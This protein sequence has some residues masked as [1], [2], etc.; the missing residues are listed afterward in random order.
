MAQQI[1]V[2]KVKE[3]IS[4]LF[5][6]TLKCE[7]E[8]NSLPLT[9]K[10]IGLS[11]IDLTYLFFEIEKEFNIKIDTDNVLNYEFNTIN[12][13]ADIVAKANKLCKL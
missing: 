11:A 5:Q 9:G 12:G 6:V 10:I 1:I 4:Q 2:E 13:I 3:I 7:E 8:T